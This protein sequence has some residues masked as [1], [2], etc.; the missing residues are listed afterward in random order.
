MSTT[1]KD[2][3]TTRAQN[4]TTRTSTGRPARRFASRLAAVALSAA[5]VLGLATAPQGQQHLGLAGFSAQQ[6]GALGQD[7][8]Y[9]QQLAATI[10]VQSAQIDHFSSLYDKAQSQLAAT[11]AA[12]GANQRKLD[13][14]DEALETTR[15]HLLA[16]AVAAYIAGQGANA[17][18]AFLTDTPNQDAA[19]QE[20]QSISDTTLASAVRRY[21]LARNAVTKT[22][23]VLAA[24]QRREHEEAALLSLAKAQAQAEVA[25][26]QAELSSVEVNISQLLAAAHAIEVASEAAQGVPSQGLL[27]YS[28]NVPPPSPTWLKEA[29]VAISVALAQVGK[30]YQWG[31][32]GPNSFDCSGLVMYAWAAAGVDL[33]HYSVYQYDSTIHIPPSDLRPGDIVFYNSPYDG[34]L[35]H[36]ALYIGNGDV[37]QAPMTGLDVMVTSITWAGP[38][39]AY[40]QP[41]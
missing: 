41:A 5:A 16:D 11:Q 4:P 10:A 37:V 27:P 32:A 31:G 18:L 21:R 40:G 33:P 17:S 8:T 6:A 39:V 13:R 20:Y 28:T 25:A 23:A 3:D 7:E 35:G 36:E 34:P 24:E 38:P 22:Q 30:P 14:L 1:T 9:A 2:Q 12:L 26:E 15:R 19:R 29:Q